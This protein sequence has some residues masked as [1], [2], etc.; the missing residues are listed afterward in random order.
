MSGADAVVLARAGAGAAASGAWLPF[1]RPEGALTLYCVPHAGGSASAFRPWFGRI[2]AVAVRPVQ[3]PGRE[4]RLRETP[5]R[6]MTAYVRDLARA[7]RADV[8]ATRKPYAVYGHSLGAWAAF[9]LVRALRRGGAPDPE[10]L[11]VSGAAAPDDPPY[12]DGPPVG[13]MTEPD[14]VAL[15]RR[16]GGTPEW[17]LRDP[18]MLAVIVPRFRGDFQV[19]ESYRYEPEPPLDV[20]ITAISASADPRAGARAMDG[21]RRQT[22]R[23]FTAHTLAGGH[24]AVLEQ[25]EL[26]LRHLARALE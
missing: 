19:K 15:L 12:D 6:D 1:A 7:V 24:F 21:W 8:E 16:I 2:G 13:R 11:V 3:P 17:M 22:A 10:H 14:V 25:S 26:T 20:P 9:E 23:R 4:T 5:Y 18:R